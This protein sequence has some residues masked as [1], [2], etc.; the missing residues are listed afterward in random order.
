MCLNAR[1]FFL[2]ILLFVYCTCSSGHFLSG[3]LSQISGLVR[4]N[5][6]SK[7]LSSSAFAEDERM[8]KD[9]EKLEILQTNA[10]LLLTCTILTDRI[11]HLK[12]MVATQTKKAREERRRRM[13]EL[14]L[15]EASTNQ[16]KEDNSEKVKEVEVMKE[17]VIAARD[18]LAKIKIDLAVAE[19][20]AEAEAAKKEELQEK[21]E[22]KLKEMEKTFSTKLKDMEHKLLAK[23]E[24][25]ANDVGIT[26]SS[27][28]NV[29]ASASTPS[30]PRST[31][32][33]SKKANAAIRNRR[34]SKT[35]RR[36]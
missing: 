15:M 1:L 19:R 18:E 23:K 29:A 17:A 14:A 4:R 28:K 22:Q 6:L 26:K 11:S 30:L 25:N 20:K 10:E 3:F 13:E 35:N 36:R 27:S 34:T 24:I 21:S 7:G 16:L 31:S 2:F 32:S 5:P 8:F 12:A 9:K 33:S